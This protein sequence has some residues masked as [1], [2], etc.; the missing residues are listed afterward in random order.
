MAIGNL[1]QKFSAS[2]NI[3]TSAVSKVHLGTAYK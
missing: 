1:S 2:N 3:Y